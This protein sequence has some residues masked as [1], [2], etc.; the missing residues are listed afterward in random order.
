MARTAKPVDDEEM[1]CAV[2]QRPIVP[3]RDFVFRVDGRLE[4]LECPAAAWPAARLAPE[5]PTT[6]QD[7]ADKSAVA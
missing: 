2:C 4:H 3:T 6:P 1:T 5:P 7:P